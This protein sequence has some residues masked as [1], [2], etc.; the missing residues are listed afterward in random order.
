MWP[1]GGRRDDD[2]ASDSKCSRRPGR[3]DLWPG[4]RAESE[5]WVRD[6]MKRP[7]PKRVIPCARTQ[8]GVQ[9]ARQRV[10]DLL[11]RGARG[12]APKLCAWVRLGRS[13][14]L[15]RGALATFIAG[16][17][18]IHQPVHRQMEF[19]RIAAGRTAPRM[20]ERSDRPREGKRH[21]TPDRFRTD[22]SGYGGNVSRSVLPLAVHQFSRIHKSTFR[23]KCRTPRSR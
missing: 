5:A 17:L 20:G 4:Y 15:E 7:L 3:G 10:L 1:H 13:V 9:I 19:L 18:K 23:L 21:A 11:E 14:G 16:D 12:P 6:G 8:A 22:R 2:R